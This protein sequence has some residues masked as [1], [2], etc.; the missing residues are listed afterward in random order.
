MTTKYIEQITTSLSAPLAAP[1]LNPL[2][3]A[4]DVDDKTQA[5]KL[6]EDL[7]D[8][9]GGF[10]IGP[11]LILRYGPSIIQTVAQFAP[12]FLDMKY[13]DIPS[14]MVSAARASFDAG[15]KLITVH[16][17]AGGPALHELTKLE[18]EYNKTGK[19]KILCVTILTSFDSSSLPTILKSQPIEQHVIELVKLV[20]MSG[21]TGI[22]CSPHELEALQEFDDMYFITPGIRGT[23]IQVTEAAQDQKR[24]MSAKEAIQLGANGIVVGRPIIEAKN[25]REAATKYCMSVFS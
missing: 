13:F 3:V 8:I 17:Q 20:Q 14:T 2:C 1:L 11:R 4:L 5:L 18:E 16:A 25:P 22:V 6:A 7:G 24:V 9:V 12:V 21:L 10:K 19:V 15:A 23:D